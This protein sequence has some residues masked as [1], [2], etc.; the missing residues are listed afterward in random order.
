MPRYRYRAM[1][2]DGRILR[3]ELDAATPAELDI[4]L[5]G[6][7]LDLLSSAPARR[8]PWRS[9]IPRRELIHF[10]FHLEQFLH[11]GMPILESLA[12]LRDASALPG[13]RD[14]LAAIV[15]DIEGGLELAQAMA[16]QAHVFDPV[17]V[18][19]VRAGEE[20]GQLPTVLHTLA[21]SLKRDDEFAAFARHI[22]IYPAI[23][24]SVILAALGVSLIFVVPELAR[25]FVAMGQPLPAQTRLL[26]ALSQFLVAHGVTLVTGLAALALAARVALATHPALRLRLDRLKLALPVLGDI[27][28]KIMLARFS[29]LFALMYASGI[30]IVA[31]LQSAE[32]VVGNTAVR[33]ELHQV[34]RAIAAGSPVSDAFL[35]TALFPPLVSRMLRIG[36]TTGGLDTA[37]RNLGYFYERDVREAIAR[38]QASIEP[39]LTVALGA[40]LLWVMS[41]VMLPIYDIATHMRM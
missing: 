12:D 26:L 40:L 35:A 38:L 9:A 21:E 8:A 39:L 7:H 32:G 17:M 33:A 41:A 28:R 25:L 3:G 30:T 22:T 10:C 37:L 1:D 11:A 2:A 14:A 19:L 18:G 20:A 27:Q 34:G 16:R 23:A 6:R 29:S 24:G 4:R 15:E 5:R 13:F 31:A 36:E